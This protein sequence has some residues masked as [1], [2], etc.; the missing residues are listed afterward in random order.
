MKNIKFNKILFWVFIILMII[1][2]ITLVIFWIGKIN[3][4][5]IP[6]S[7]MAKELHLND[8]QRKQL[9]ALIDEHRKE[10]RVLKDKIRTAKNELF[11]LAKDSIA[12]ENKKRLAIDKTSKY[13]GQLDSLTLNHFQKIRSICNDDQKKLFE[14][15][16]KK[17][18]VTIG[19]S[20]TPANDKHRYEIEK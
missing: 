13:I 12:D 16:L 4:A 19:G 5:P 14:E 8:Q 1:N 3:K 20:E 11:D 7:I 15:L 10:S 18:A 6:K 9:Y 17:M 2:I